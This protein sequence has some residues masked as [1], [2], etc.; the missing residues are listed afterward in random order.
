[1]IEQAN[2]KTGVHR[3]CV[4]VLDDSRVER[5]LTQRLL[6]AT[7]D[8]EL[9]DD[10][11][12]VLGRIAGGALPDVLI[13]DWHMPNMSGADV[14]RFLRQANDAA[15]LPILVLTAAGSQEDVLEGLAAGAND[16]VTKSANQ[17]ELLARVGTLAQV[18]SL[19]ESLK[20]TELLARKSREDADEANLAK[21]VFLGIV[22]HELRTPL[23]SILGCLDC[24]LKSLSTKRRIVRG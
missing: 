5:E 4:W 18:K 12:T 8:V 20:R 13:L 1:M 6:T 2:T 24:S 21:D 11:A 7:H 19:H 9:Y 15:S 10:G 14:C 17:A 3:P 22:S 23:N 16:F